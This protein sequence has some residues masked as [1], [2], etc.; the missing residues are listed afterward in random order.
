M[1]LLI[2]VDIFY[3]SESKVK[4]KVKVKLSLCS[5]NHAI[6]AYWGSGGITPHTLDLGSRLR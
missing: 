2:I 5:K 4:V 1:F 6:K 3:T